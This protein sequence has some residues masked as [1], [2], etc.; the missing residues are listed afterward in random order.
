V[1]SLV[2]A[3]GKDS[4]VTSPTAYS[5]N[6]LL[7]LGVVTAAAVGHHRRA[8]LSGVS[9]VYTVGVSCVMTLSFSRARRVHCS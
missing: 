4:P 9:I 3:G 5:P 2:E 7:P 6:E 1:A 8:G